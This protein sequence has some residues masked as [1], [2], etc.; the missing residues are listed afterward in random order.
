M[1]VV[2]PN[3]PQTLPASFAEAIVSV[4]ERSPDVVEDW[5]SLYSVRI[6]IS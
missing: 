3:V 5:A 4:L 6:G 2:A 1:V